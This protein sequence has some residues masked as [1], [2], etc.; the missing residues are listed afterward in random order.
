MNWTPNVPEIN[1]KEVQNKWQHSKY[2]RTER[3][4]RK[5]IVASMKPEQ[6]KITEYFTKILTKFELLL[7]ENKI[8]QE[9][10]E[11]TANQI[12]VTLSEQC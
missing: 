5:L 4:K 6:N 7:K 11:N 1:K 12:R 3:N 8:L 2:S 9:Q 10:L